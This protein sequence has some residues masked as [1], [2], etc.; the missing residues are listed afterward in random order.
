MCLFLVPS[1]LVTAQNVEKNN[2]SINTKIAIQI[3]AKLGG[4]PWRITI[5]SKV[6][7]SVNF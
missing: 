2:M 3:N 7:L 1:Q 5:P 4:A 6:I